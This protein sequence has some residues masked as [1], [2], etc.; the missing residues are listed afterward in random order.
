MLLKCI[1]EKHKEIESNLSNPSKATID[2]LLYVKRKLFK[3]I[4]QHYSD[5]SDYS[6]EY[7]TP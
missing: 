4:K 6:K 2:A 3:V 7:S 5:Y 1:K